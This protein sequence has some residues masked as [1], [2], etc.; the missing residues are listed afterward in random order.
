MA[1][2][3]DPKWEKLAEDTRNFT[4]PKGTTWQ[5]V[6]V[7]VLIPT[8]F[9]ALWRD[10]DRPF[11]VTGTAADLV[12][13]VWRIGE[14]DVDIVEECWRHAD[15]EPQALE[16]AARRED[17]Q[18]DLIVDAVYKEIYDRYVSFCLE[19]ESSLPHATSVTLCDS[20]ATLS[21]SRDYNDGYIRDEPWR[22]SH[23]EAV[24]RRLDAVR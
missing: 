17:E 11:S 18:K 5:H 24:E 21:L 2:K 16:E 10:W 22:T 8:A 9:I 1:P 14:F 19:L 13:T 3:L 20:H 15:A 7:I 23:V 6:L 4:A 12:C